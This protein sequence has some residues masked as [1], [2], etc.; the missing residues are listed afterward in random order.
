MDWKKRMD[1]IVHAARITPGM[2]P[3][4]IYAVPARALSLGV[5]LRFACADGGG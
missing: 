2:N 3:P 5:L 1:L 4:T